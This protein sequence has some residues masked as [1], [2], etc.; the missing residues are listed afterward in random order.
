MKR[1]GFVLRPNSK[2]IFKLFE[3]IKQKFE[4]RGVEV[5]LSDIYSKRCGNGYVNFEDMCRE[6][7][8]LISLGGDGTLLALVRKSYGFDKPIL[9][10]N[11]GNLGFLAD[12]RVEE[13]DEL[14]DLLLKGDYRVDNRM[15]IYGYIETKLKKH[16]FYA[17]NDVVITRPTIS[18]MAKINA[19]ID[20]DWFNSY[21]GDGLLISTP[22]GSTAYNLSLGGP[23]LYPLSKVFIMTPIA[24]H[25]LTQRP[26]VVPSDFTIHFTSPDRLVV[27]V[28]GQ[29]NFTLY[30]EDKLV[31]KGAIKDAKLI[32]QREHSYFKVLREKLSWGGKQ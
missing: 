27:M 1:V 13:V 6:V 30:P 21:Y 7:D 22:T 23:I 9:G 5:Y 15:L 10:I 12:T 14:I 28:D 16:K 8:I 26:L 29:D 25:S 19:F 2:D 17:F 31:I 3:N 20:N 18:H 11:A 4:S 24:P 32:H